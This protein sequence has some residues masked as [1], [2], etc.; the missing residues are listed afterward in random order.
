MIL[1]T[2]S[3]IFMPIPF[4]VRPLAAV[5]LV[6]STRALAAHAGEPAPDD[7]APAEGAAPVTAKEGAAQADASPDTP[8]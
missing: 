3:L 8:Q 1:I 7:A 4:R 5:I 6:F 2:I